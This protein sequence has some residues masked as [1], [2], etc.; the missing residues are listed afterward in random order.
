MLP[1]NEK[2]VLTKLKP[3]YLSLSRWDLPKCMHNIN[4]SQRPNVWKNPDF[5]NSGGIGQELVWTP[6]SESLEWIKEI[7][8]A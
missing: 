4:I 6:N 8:Q 5:F 7:L 3:Q 2:R 1:F